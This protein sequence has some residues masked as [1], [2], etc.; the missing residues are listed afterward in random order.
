MTS[1]WN[2]EHVLNLIVVMVAQLVNT[3][4]TGELYTLDE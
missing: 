3:L 1:L 2:D 4:K